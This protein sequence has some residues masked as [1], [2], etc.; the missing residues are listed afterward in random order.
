MRC[1]TCV[2]VI[3]PHDAVAQWAARPIDLGGGNRFQVLVIGP[4]GVPEITDEQRALAEPELAVLSAMA[5]GQSE[6]VQKASE[7]AAAAIAGSRQ[8][9][10]QHAML[11]L[12]LIVASLSQAAQSALASM[13]PAKY[14]YQST[15]AKQYFAQGRA[16]GQTQGQAQGRAEMLARL[17]AQK[18]GVLDADVVERVR[19]ASVA[20]L[21]LWTERLLTSNS[22]EEFF[23]P[24]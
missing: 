6:N 14:E 8:L 21:E 7:I 17:L 4:V 9:D 23:R 18:F 16:E 22:L 15:I 3:T 5:H 19:S 10:A 1:P 12:D 11:Y 2:L 24:A 20:Q 13:D